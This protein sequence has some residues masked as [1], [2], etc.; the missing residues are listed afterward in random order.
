[1]S[2]VALVATD[3]SRLVNILP[4]ADFTPSG[5]AVVNVKSLG[6]DTQIVVDNNFAFH[7]YYDKSLLFAEA[8]GD[9]AW[10]QIL[11]KAWAKYNGNYDR[12]WSGNCVEPLEWLVGF[13]GFFYFLW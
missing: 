13:P 10:V 2:A 8:M 11:E 3:P 1:M 5:A 6:E 12:I 7:E 9:E 4:E